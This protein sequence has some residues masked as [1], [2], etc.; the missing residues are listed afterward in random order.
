MLEKSAS[1]WHE[2]NNMVPAELASIILAYKCIY[3]LMT[4]LPL[5]LRGGGVIPLGPRVLRHNWF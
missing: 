4:G 1:E 5:S 2:A 3:G